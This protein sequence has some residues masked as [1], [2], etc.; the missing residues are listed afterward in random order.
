MPCQ[1]VRQHADKILVPDNLK[2]GVVGYDWYT[3]V[4]NKVYHEMAEHAFIAGC[5]SAVTVLVI[6]QIDVA[7]IVRPGEWVVKRTDVCSSVL[8]GLVEVPR[9][10]GFDSTLVPQVPVIESHRRRWNQ[11]KRIPARHPNKSE[12]NA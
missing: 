1:I 9:V 7:R 3:P 6:Q 2:T 4:I 8:E 11:R 12:D 10:I 5:V